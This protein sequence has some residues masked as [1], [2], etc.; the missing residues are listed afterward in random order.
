SR[1]AI[2]IILILF[3][4]VLARQLFSKASLNNKHPRDA[5]SHHTLIEGRWKAVR[6]SLGLPP[7]P[8]TINS[9]AVIPPSSP[10]LR[11]GKLPLRFDLHRKRAEADLQSQNRL[12]LAAD[13]RDAPRV[14]LEALAASF[15]RIAAAEKEMAG[16]RSKHEKLPVG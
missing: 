11:A 1:L 9:P 14:S 4:A 7:L 2:I 8:D 3:A 12:H 16:I 6:A 13:V 15:R 10:P 5:R